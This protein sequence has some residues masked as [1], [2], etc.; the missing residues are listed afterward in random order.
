[1]VIFLWWSGSD[2]LGYIVRGFAKAACGEKG[3]KAG[4]PLYKFITSS[5]ARTR[6]AEALV[7]TAGQGWQDMVACDGGAHSPGRCA[8]ETWRVISAI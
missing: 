6:L 7:N 1:M 2:L 4:R 3:I 5:A 8:I